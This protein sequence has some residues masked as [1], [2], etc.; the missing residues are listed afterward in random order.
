MDTPSLIDNASRRDFIKTASKAT[1]GL[2]VLSG[3]TIPFVHAAEVNTI[4]TVLIGCGGRGTGAASNALTTKLPIKLVAMADVSDKRMESSF[5]TLSA[6]HPER[7]SVSV[8]TKFVGFDAY[9]KAMDMLSPGDVAICATPP[10]FRWVHFKYAIERGINIFMEKP[11]S[12]DGPT[13]KRMLALNEEAKKKGIKVAVGLMCRHCNA[14]KELYNRIQDGAIGDIILSRAYRMSGPIADCFVA[15]RDPEQYPSELQWQIQKFHGFLWASGGSFSDFLIHNIDEACWMKN[16]WPVEAQAIGGRTNRGDFIDQNF[17]NYSVEYTF[18]DGTKF[19]MEG[20]N[21]DGCRMDHSTH[22]HG[23]KGM[24]VVSAAGHMPALSL[25]SKTHMP[26]R[27]QKPRA[28]RPA[29]VQ[30][31]AKGKPLPQ[32]PAP[33]PEKMVLPPNVTWFAQQPERNP[34]DLEWEDFIDAIRNNKPYNEMERGVRASLAT[35]MGRMAAHTGQIITYDQMLNCTHEFA[36]NVDQLTLDGPAP[37]IADA[38]GKYPI[39]MAGII[40]ETEYKVG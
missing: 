12:V 24:A 5:Q 14:R 7:M 18:K 3:I 27:V 36:P 39:P 21:Q 34:Y 16:D 33:P 40:K 10:G 15:P 32:P 37:I 1:A 6:K 4:K 9:K 23:T 17:D 25:I 20:R 28:P 11:L 35:S 29:K 19:Y 13:G 22:V 30:L 38:S 2:S 31:D 26:V 8:D